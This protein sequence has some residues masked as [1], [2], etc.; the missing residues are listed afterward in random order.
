MNK[1]LDLKSLV[2]T[3]ML[4]TLTYVLKT[5]MAFLPNIHLVAVIFVATTVVYRSK[6]LITVYT[7][8]FLEGLFGG[9]TTWWIPNLYTWLILWSVVMILPKNMP[10]KVAPVVYMIVCSLH[11][12][13]YGVLYAPFQALVYGLDFEGT[14][15]WIVAGAPFDLIHGVS[16]FVCGM[17]IIP[18]ITVLNYKHVN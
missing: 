11:G 6:A 1:K 8:V 15:A 3:I 4:G 10:K 12:F 18:I 13:L 14:L 7:Y 5:V 2:I 16:N 9:F 17:L